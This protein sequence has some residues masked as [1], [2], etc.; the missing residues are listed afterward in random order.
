LPELDLSQ[1]VAIGRETANLAG[2][3]LLRLFASET[4][5]LYAKERAVDVVSEADLAAERLIADVLGERRPDDALLSEEVAT[6]NGTTGLRWLVDP[7]DGTI[8]F[9]RGIPHWAVS[10]A[11]E[12]EEHLL[13]GVVHDPLREETFEVARGSEPTLNGVRMKG[14]VARPISEALLTGSLGH[15]RSATQDRQGR[16]ASALHSSFAQVRTMGS[17]A[18]DLAWTAAGRCDAFYHEEWAQP[19]DLA[20]GSLLCEARGLEVRLLPPAADGLSNRVIVAPPD[21]VNE[22]VDLT[23]HADRGYGP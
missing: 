8:N 18:L 6:R 16:L 11:C 12:S 20:A 21:V 22:I 3:E 17:A 13:V 5:A 9:L 19:W 4:E 23:N 1:L 15:T 7:L 14:R 10:V 2:A